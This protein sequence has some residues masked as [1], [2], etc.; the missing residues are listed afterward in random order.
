M[1]YA[2]DTFQ[3]QVHNNLIIDRDSKSRMDEN[4]N[5]YLFPSGQETWGCRNLPRPIL[6][7]QIACNGLNLQMNPRSVRSWTRQT[8]HCISFYLVMILRIKCYDKV[9][10]NTQQKSK[11][12]RSDSIV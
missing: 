4:S 6:I 1:E 11:K 10:K 9:L 8:S 12:P 5:E 2:P 7:P 3:F